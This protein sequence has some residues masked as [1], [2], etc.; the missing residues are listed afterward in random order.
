MLMMII[1]IHTLRKKF[2][3]NYYTSSKAT[4]DCKNPKK[5]PYF[6]VNFII[7]YSKFSYISSKISYI[8]W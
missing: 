6:T 5:L 8:V 7:Q 4:T 3:K 2:L 1:I